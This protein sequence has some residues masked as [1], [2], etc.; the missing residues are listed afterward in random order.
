MDTSEKNFESTV[1]GHLLDHDYTQ[2][3]SSA[4]DRDLCLDPDMLFE[5][6]Y[7]TQPKMWDKLKHQH[8]EAVKERFLKRLTHEIGVRGTLDVLRKGII[9]LGCKFDLAFFK[10]ESGLNEEHQHLHASNILSVMRQVHYSKQNNNSIDLVLFLNGLPIITAELKNPLQ[11][12]NVQHAVAQYRHDRDPKEPLLAF[13]RCLAHFAVDTDLVYMTTHLRGPKTTFLPFNKGNGNGAGNPDNPDGFKTAYLWEHV[14][15]KDS[16][17]DILN[18]FVLQHDI[19]DEKGKKTG[20]QALIFPRYHQLDAVRR[21]VGHAKAS[22]AGQN[23]LIQHSAGSGKSNSI[24]WLAHR[25]A[26]L[27]D[28]KDQ[29]VFDSIIVVTDRR[30]L[31]RQLRN[32][33]RS[34][35]KTVGVVE[36]VEQGSAQLKLAL[37]GG[38]DIIIT[39]L[40]KFPFVVD[41]LGQLPGRR[42]AVVV[43]EA[44]SSQSGESTK[45]LK[46]VL[47]VPDLAAAEMED[48]VDESDEE[49]D[50]DQVNAAVEEVMKKRGRLKNVSFFAF[51]ATP[52]QKTLELFGTR[53]QD[54]SFLPFSLYSMRQAI[55]EKFIL[56]V[57]QNYTTFR[58]YF[59]LLKRIENDPHYERKKGI[60]LLKSYAD[61]HEHGIRTKAAQMIEH[62]HE[63][64]KDRIEGQ[65]KAMVVTR[66][67]LHA[68]RFKQA[69]DRYLKEQ[70][71]PYKALVAFSGTVTDP[72]TG[73]TFTEAKMN[74][75]AETQTAETFKGLE[76]RFLIVANKFQTGFDQPLLHTMYVDKKLGGVNAV[77]T[78]SRL[79]RTHPAKEETVVLDFANA[80]EEIQK[81]FQPYYA[82]TLLT[83]GTDPNKLY[84]LQ[85]ALADYHIFESSDVEAFAAIYFSKKG[86]QEQLHTVLNPVVD[87]YQERDEDEQTTFRGHL[88]DYVRLY[89]FL[90]QLLTFT[91]ADLEKLYQFARYLLRKLPVPVDKLPTEI[92]ENI[93]MDSYRIQRTSS[94]SIKLLDEAGQLKPISA[95]G[96]GQGDT[97]EKAPLSEI[98]QYIN[99]NYG[100]DF[101][102]ADKVA[103]FAQDMERRLADN[104]SLARALDTEI[105]PSV[106]NRRLAFDQFY[107]DAREDMFESNT[108]IYKK[109]VDD[110]TFDALF[111]RVLFDKLQKGL[112]GGAGR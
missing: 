90:S 24:A 27:H 71:Y 12:Q 104:Q 20:E 111:R 80:A 3:P 110:P 82:T 105:N 100:T 45:S 77:Q 50:E 103:Y 93:N 72:D 28:A 64:I 63:Q 44:H 11:S 42:F 58:V 6:L 97:Q 60:Y 34:F 51:T 86:K 16:L 76:Y 56:D 108:E 22:G 15:A 8:G 2:R 95:L 85:R 92:T 74:G 13:G 99:E 109:L 98:V 33:V 7:T 107:A 96:M 37:Q 67:R 102:Q 36:A 43:D 10:P 83:E 69:F 52:K 29:R 70:K 53:Q 89:A 91:D 94:G 79:N 49:S 46:Q 84:D 32:T 17:L 4:Y 54:G 66:S 106:E 87:L 5:F 38:K 73:E 25:L 26:S 61:L 65:A 68:V 57:L 40:Q 31:D 101:T 48:A 55:E 81:A 59:G 35:A 30:V 112:E 39:T 1:E 47:A 14:W 19:L 18:H 78:L 62:F 23:Y 9:D 75:V 41:G 88:N 21:L